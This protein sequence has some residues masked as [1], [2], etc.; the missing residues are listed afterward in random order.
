MTERKAK[1]KW[2]GT[3]R[4]G[5]GIIKFAD[6]QGPYTYQSRFEEGKGINPEQ[7]I[8]AAHSG[9]FTMALNS[10][11]EKAGFPADVVETEAFVTL[12]KIDGANRITEIH[13]V[14]VAKVAGIG[15]EEFARLAE[16]AKVGC[17]ISAALAA[18]PSITLDAQLG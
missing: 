11:L 15:E 1:A 14:T 2:E 5:K 13:L 18:V 10:A 6:Y 12:G 3:L 16:A 17:P 7:L 9:C 4:E 8:A